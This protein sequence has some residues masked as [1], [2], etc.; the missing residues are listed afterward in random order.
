MYDWEGDEGNAVC[1]AG[2]HLLENAVCMTNGKKCQTNAIWMTWKYFVWK[3]CVHDWE[4]FVSKCCVNDRGG[5]L[6]GHAI[7]MTGKFVKECCVHD[8]WKQFSD[9]CCIDDLEDICRKMLCAGQ[10]N[11]CWK[12]RR[13][14][15]GKYFLEN[16]VCTWGSIYLK[17][18]CAGRGG[19]LAG[20]TVSITEANIWWG[21]CVHDRLKHLTTR[22][23]YAWQ[24]EQLSVNAVCMEGHICK[25]NVVCMTEGI[26]WQDML[27]VW[28]C[29]VHD[30]WRQSSG[31]HFMHVGQALVRKC[32]MHD[33]ETFFSNCFFLLHLTTY[34]LYWRKR[35]MQQCYII[36][37]SANHRQ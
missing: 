37:S 30:R 14:G 16:A 7:C 20:H 9:K 35:Q 27:H 25:K 17:M 10:G 21:I 15:Q 24:G 26:L 34:I 29:W 36:H 22:L 5:Y 33:L 13:A 8:R 31:K 12:M 4:T 3:C 28:K 23:L 11:I 32:C 2:K 6:E 1:I 18:L 19:P